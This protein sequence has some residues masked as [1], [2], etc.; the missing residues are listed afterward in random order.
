MNR[1]LYDM[2]PTLLAAAKNAKT[3]VARA[4]IEAAQGKPYKNGRDAWFKPFEEIEDDL[5]A[6]EDK[7]RKLREHE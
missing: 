6:V 4:S 3:L 1:E 5:K 2:V 7:I